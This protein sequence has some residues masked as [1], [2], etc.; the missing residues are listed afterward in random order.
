M[1]KVIIGCPRSGTNYTSELFKTNNIQIGHEKIGIDGIC[2]W[3]LIGLND[4]SPWGPSYT[5]V[6]NYYG[7]K[8]IEFF[9]QIRNP[10]ECI[11]SMTTLQ[12]VSFNYIK[13]FIPIN[14]DDTILL[15]CM[16]FWYYWNLRAE[17]IT[18]KR[19]KIEYVKEYFNLNIDI[20]NKKINTRTHREFEYD[21]FYKEDPEL[22]EK[23]IELI[24]KYD[25]NNNRI[26]QVQPYQIL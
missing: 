14:D 11:S 4:Q 19:Y 12:N 2:S 15:K 7:E 25:G 13:N 1:K 22:T 6:I 24:K 10:L 17:T 23:I 5:E 8:N 9:H 26:E 16:K 3:T 20:K 18:D 21:D